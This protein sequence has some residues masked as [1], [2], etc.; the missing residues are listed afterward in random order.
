RPRRRSHSDFPHVDPA[1]ARLLLGMTSAPSGRRGPRMPATSPP[2]SLRRL[3]GAEPDDAE[4]LRRYAATGD[5]EAF[6]GLVC[7]HARTVLAAIEDEI[8]RLPEAYR[9]P[10]V[11]CYLDGLSKTAAADRLGLSA[12]AFRGRLDRGRD[13]LRATLARRGLAPAAVVG[14]LV[15]ATGPATAELLP[16]T[17]GVCVRGEPVPAGV[18]ALTAGRSGVVI[19]VGLAAG[20]LVLAGGLGLVGAA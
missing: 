6:A 8:A 4:L 10:L 20:L 7:R 3:V 18:A 11:L 2:L 5:P 13:R 17:V 1:P 12:D 19:K 16:R 9:L 14:L 15:P